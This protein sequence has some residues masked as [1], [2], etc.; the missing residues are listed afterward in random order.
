MTQV[1]AIIGTLGVI[2]SVVFAGWQSREVAKQTRIQNS[3]A[4]TS[5]MREAVNALHNVLGMMVEHPDLRPFFYEGQPCPAEGP[6]RG[7][8]LAM[9]EM[10]ADTAETGMLTHQQVLKIGRAHL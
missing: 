6:L 8:V 4:G 1:L 2:A 10:L 7:S 9:A 3:L 5:S